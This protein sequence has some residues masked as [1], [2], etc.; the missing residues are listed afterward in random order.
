ML[1]NWYQLWSNRY[2][3]ETSEIDW[4]CVQMTWNETE[5]SGYYQWTKTAILHNNHIITTQKINEYRWNSESNTLIPSI[6]NVSIVNPILEVKW[7]GPLNEDMKQYE[8]LI[9]FGSDN[10]TLFTFVR[11]IDIFNENYRQDVSNLLIEYHYTGYYKNPLSSYTEFC[12]K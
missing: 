7:V 10:N 6:H 11:D 9:T 3:Q 1:G 8:Y 5:W 12:F 4:D 2:V